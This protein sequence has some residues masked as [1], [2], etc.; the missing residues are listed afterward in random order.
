[1][2]CH[3]FASLLGDCS[4]VTD[5]HSWWWK[6]FDLARRGVARGILQKLVFRA[7]AKVILRE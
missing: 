4:V 3:H 5:K 1:M 7:V 6:G 2:P